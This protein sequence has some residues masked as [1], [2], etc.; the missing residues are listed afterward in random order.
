LSIDA[1][2]CKRATRGKIVKVG[3]G[4]SVGRQNS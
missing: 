4:L 1:A 3:R 2:L